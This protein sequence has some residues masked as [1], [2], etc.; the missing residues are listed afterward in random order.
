[1]PASVA[2]VNVNYEI[3]PP[4]C[5]TLTLTSSVHGTAATASPANSSGCSAGTY[6]AGEGITLTAH[7]SAGYVVSKWTG[8]ND[9]ALKTTGNTLT[10]PVGARLVNVKYASTACG[11]DAALIGCWLMEE[12]GGTTLVDGSS[13]GY[14]GTIIGSPLWVTGKTGSYALS[15]NGTSQ[16]A[17]VPDNDSL[18]FSIPFTLAMW[19]A[20]ALYGT[21]NI[22]A[23][24]TNAGVNGYEIGLSSSTSTW[25]QK[26]FFRLNQ[27]A[28]GDTYR[29]NSTTLYPYDSS[30]WFF[31]TATYDGATMRLYINGVQEAFVATTTYPS[32][33]TLALGIGAQP[34]N[35]RWY[36]G[37][38]DDV[39]IY[40][41]ALDASEV[42][43][44][45]NSA[46]TCHTLTLTSGANGTAPTASPTNSTGCSAGSYVATEAITLTAHPNGGYQVAAWT[47][48]D[49]D[50]LTTLTNILSMPNGARTVNANYEQIPPT[51]YALTLTAGTNGS[52]V[53]ASPTNSTGC[54]AG[55]YVAGESIALSAHPDSGYQVAAWTGTNN[56]SL[57]T[58]TNTLTMPAGIR[59]VHVDYEVITLT[60]YALTI[61]AGVNGSTPAA[62]PLKS[63]TCPTNG[64]YIAGESIA[65]TA[66]PSMGFQVSGW[67]G[68]INDASTALTNTVTMPPSIWTA[69][70]TYTAYAPIISGSTGVAGTTLSY[71]DGGAMTATA[72]GSGNYSFTVPYNWSGLVTASHVGYYFTPAN[73]IYTNV[74]SDQTAQNYSG[75]AVS[76]PTG[77][78]CADIATKATTAT[79]D[80]KPQ[81]KVWF[82]DGSWWS[83][84]PTSASGASSAGTW[85][86][87]LT[88]LTWSEVL[89]LST[90]TDTHADIRSVGSLAHILLYVGV[91]TQ[92]VSVEYAA[93]TYQLW[94]VRSTPVNLTY[95]TTE[96]ATIDVDSTGVMWYAAVNPS[97]QVVVYYS[98]SPYSTW[99]GPVVL[100][101]GVV[102]SDDIAVV[103]ALP[104]GTVGVFWANEN[105]SVRRFGF[106]VHV[107]GADPATW[108]ADE[109]PASQS[110][111]NVGSGMSDDHMNLAVASDGTLYAAVKTSYDTAGYPKM[112]LL[113]R[114]SNG[115]WD[116]LYGVDEVGTRPIVLL[117][118]TDGTLDYI[119]TS[120]EGNNPIVY[121]QSPIGVISFG[122]RTTLQ[123]SSYNDVSS[124]K[125][126]IT[127]ELVTIFSNGSTMGGERCAPLGTT[128]TISGNA[129]IAGATLSYTD[130][131]PKTATANGAGDYTITV[132]YNWSGTVTPLMGTYT[133]APVSKTYSNVVTN[134]TGEDYSVSIAGAG[135]HFDGTDD[136]VTFGSAGG[137]GVTNFTLETWF[138]WTGSGACTTT[139][140]T[141]GLQ[142][143]IPLIAKGRPDGTDGTNKDI[144]YFLGIDC[145]TGVLAVDFED[146]ASGTNHPYKGTL[147]ATSNAWHHAAVTYNSTTGLY[148]LYLDGNVAGT[149][150][151]G[152]SIIPRSDST[153]PTSLGTLIDSAGVNAGYFQGVIDEARIW[154]VVRTQTQILSEI[155]YEITSGTGL[156]AR[157]GMDEGTGITITSS[158]GVFTG[159]LTNG[160]TWVPGA[161][162]DLVLSPSSPTL[163]SP[164]DGSVDFALPP[165]LTVHVTDPRNAPITVSFYGRAR[166]GVTGADFSLVAIPDAQNYASTY[167]SI[168]YSQMNWVVNNKTTDNIKFVMSLG[169][170]INTAANSSEWTNATTA[171]DLLTAGGVQY[172][173]SLGNHDGA[174]SST[175]AF[176]SAFATRLATAPNNCVGMGVDM[177]NTYCT[178]SASGMDFIVLF[179]EYD[180]T[181]TTGS[182]PVLVWADGVLTSHATSRAI[183]VTHNLL[184][185]N[186][187]TAQGSAIYEKL[188]THANLFL[189]LG[190]HSDTTGQRS[191]TY[192]GYTV[193]SLRSDYQSVDGQQS[194]YLRVMRFSPTNDLIYVTTYSPN[195]VKSLTDTGNQFSLAYAMDGIADFELIG[196]TTVPSGSE[197]TISWS[198]LTNST[199][200]EWYA[201]ADNG[202]G[203]AV[204]STWSFTTAAPANIA[205]VITEGGPAAVNMAKNGTPLPFSLTLHATD[206]DLDTLTW[207]VAVPAIHG[208]A[209]AAGTGTEQVVTYAPT[210]D[211]LGTD[212]FVVQVSD[213]RGGTD[214]ITINVTINPVHGIDLV[215]GWNMVSF[216]LH[217]L[218]TSLNDVLKTIEGNY[219]LVYVYDSSVP[220]DPPG[221]NW[222]KADNVPATTDTLTQL[223][224]SRGFWIRM[225]TPDTLEV[226]GNVA[227]P[228]ITLHTDAGGWNLVSYAGTAA[229]ALPNVLSNN[230]V[231][232]NFTL[233]YSYH[234]GSGDP[235]KIYDRI[236]PEW[237]NTLTQFDPGWSYWIFAAPVESTWSVP[238]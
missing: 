202:G 77:L 19:V 68:T 11:N 235:W 57:K 134:L 5:Y 224:E 75:T 16:Y 175:I 185:T 105:A 15:L 133:F 204:S 9:D 43:S 106:R 62:V 167:P 201:V 25:P 144:N 139:G 39:R 114:H 169:D 217:P 223:D 187:F 92:L 152:D 58:L 231:G 86:W 21:Q 209:A 135:I 6:T 46:P 71:N 55:Q 61:N 140:S 210:T 194:G 159:T 97:N 99:N 181:M 118:E 222:L 228:S 172:G 7:P 112:A 51:C 113:V 49:N 73:R 45:Y 95:A 30:T 65:L 215:A 66:A 108:A 91:N 163:V 220:T 197:A 64:E 60:C 179:I 116:D 102:G 8:T 176:N 23:K 85:L 24:S 128:R 93:G 53:T 124:T 198:G 123:S 80:A 72:D 170:N 203:S 184:S 111:Q 28:S 14:D 89:K 103:T 155:N 234:P 200:Y 101:T 122:S 225:T 178:F 173:L 180:D 207:S 48:T 76:A 110:A 192:N 157:W 10:M 29:I 121:R 137:L 188:K 229:L 129:G 218:S 130:G 147:A 131:T 125:Q 136:Y 119:Y 13:S 69:G 227:T 88:G 214:T 17:T 117:D 216:N 42:L 33:N 150:D 67:T 79:S 74:T 54:S 32:A 2:S 153:C 141:Q 36:Q 219:D 120:A 208:L 142:N 195:Q 47:G 154:N 132:V 1:M 166:S 126:A 78:V 148:I 165:A 191:D 171:Y 156:V 3:I 31:V 81:S 161:P 100:E 44:L 41:R 232:T 143:V 22:L 4:D 12:N 26:V 107:D 145:S 127:G 56:D 205:P 158:V 199:E 70:V 233:V 211:Y 35:L 226:V 190:G 189:M 183:V 168:Y 186:N 151:I 27:V 212:S 52:A 221:N 206:A 193:Y 230:G 238:N 37:K 83:V 94:S 63:P 237:V 177:D 146:T 213:G 59:T 87:K 160:P 115:T 164:L 196:S 90:R 98:S 82:S 40:A 104:D 174:P 38:L 236:A 182:N 84:F 34:N 96:T 138:Y 18:D 162:F 20:P 109:V 149:T 50:T